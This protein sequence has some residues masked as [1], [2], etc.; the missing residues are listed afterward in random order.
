MT[1]EVHASQGDINWDDDSSDESYAP[2]DEDEDSSDEDDNDWS[3]WRETPIRVKDIEIVFD[4]FD[5]VLIDRYVE[6]RTQ[7]NHRLCQ[8]VKSMHS[9]L[10]NHSSNTSASDPSPNDIMNCFLTPP[11]VFELIGVMNKGLGLNDKHTMEQDEFVIFIRLLFYFSYYNKGPAEVC[12]IPENFPEPSKLIDLLPGNT[13]AKRGDRLMDLLQSLEGDGGVNGRDVSTTWTSVFDID[14]QLEQLFYL[15]GRQASKLC[16]VKGRTDLVIDDDKLKLRSFLAAAASLIRSKGLKSF[17]PVGNCINSNTL[18]ACLSS[19]MSHHGES[20]LS[21]TQANLMC[22]Q[23]V[24]TAS[25]L[26]FPDTVFGGDR[27]YNENELDAFMSKLLFDI[28]N[29][30]KRSPSL[31]FKF[32]NTAYK[33]NREQRVISENGPALSIGATRNANGRILYFTAWR[34]GTGRVTFLQS[35]K[36]SLSASCM[37]YIR[38]A[39]N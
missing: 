3:P 20:A 36:R 38:C 23:G 19:Y 4:S 28:L 7:I 32:G 8:Q 9:S 6:E 37:Q 27:G 31:A 13:A 25:L 33:A 2:S 24:Q 29:T 39:Y 14:Q 34:S 22:I 11:I 17:G 10:G 12:A 26:S 15:I 30:V 21:I 1:T 35:S 18:G 16:Y 5:E